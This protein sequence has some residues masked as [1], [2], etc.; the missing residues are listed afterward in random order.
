M[1]G[2]TLGL[3]SLS[4]M[5]LQCL[6]DSGTRRQRRDAERILPVRAYFLH[7]QRRISHLMRACAQLPAQLLARPHLLLVTLLLWNAAAME[8]LP[9]VLRPLMHPAVAVAV[10]VTAVLIFGEGALRAFTRVRVWARMLRPGAD[11]WGFAA[12]I[13]QA[14]CQRH[15]LAVGAA[16]A[17]LVR[18]LRVAAAPAALPLAAALDAALGPGGEEGEEGGAVAA[19]LLPRPQLRAL[20]KL[21]ARAGR[22]GAPGVLSADEATIMT[23]ALDL[24]DKRVE[25]A[26]TPLSHVFSLP[27]DAR[28]DENALE[29]ILARGHSRVPVHAPG[30]PRRV[31]GV[32][33]VKDML[34]LRLPSQ[35]LF[36]QGGFASGDGGGGAA[37]VAPPPPPP[38]VSD[39]ALRPV[40]ALR[41]STPLYAAID[42]FQAA[43]TH[44]AVVFSAADDVVDATA[45]EEAA[46]GAAGAPAPYAIGIITLEDV[47]VRVHVHVYVHAGAHTFYFCDSKDDGDVCA[48]AAAPSCAGGAAAGG[49]RG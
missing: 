23:G 17:P 15:G 37:A 30:E 35:S 25:A 3:F 33:L 10:A 19:P 4:R 32:A 1:S 14:V 11:A 39:L 27:A 22:R 42:A 40:L 21:H 46:A 28:L 45:A 8:A 20:V 12:V 41:S 24:A 5:E 29:R 2:L 16:A 13:P 36:Y 47:L 6:L 9:L 38:S 31:V 34:R 44:L 26:M 49:D 18:L 43:R 7:T 48:R